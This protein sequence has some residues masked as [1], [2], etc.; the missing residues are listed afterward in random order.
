MNDFEV[1]PIGTANEIKLSRE[2]ANAIANQIDKEEKKN[3]PKNYLNITNIFL[4]LIVVL[5][6]IGIL[7]FIRK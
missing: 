7:I 4:G 2:L 3:N 5:L 1:H 6:I